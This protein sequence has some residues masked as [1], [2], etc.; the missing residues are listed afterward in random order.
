V[1]LI[2]KA[3]SAVQASIYKTGHAEPGKHHL[4]LPLT[5]CTRAFFKET[6]PSS[7]CIRKLSSNSLF[8]E[9]ALPLAAA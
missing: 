9:S 8:K 7:V 1:R 2:A 4:Q 6:K 5:S 3:K